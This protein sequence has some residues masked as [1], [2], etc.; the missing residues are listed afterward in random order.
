MWRLL[1]C[2]QDSAEEH[3]EQVDAFVAYFGPDLAAEEAVAWCRTGD[4]HLQGAGLDVLG[5]LA[6]EHMYP[7]QP[8][9]TAVE[10][11]ADS[12]S[13]NVRWSAAYA[14][15]WLEDRRVEAPLLRLAS[16]EDSDVRHIAVSNLPLHGVE[17]PVDHPVVRALLRALE[18][19]D[20]RVRDWAAFGL[21]TRLDLDTAEVRDALAE[22]LNEDDE[23]SDTAAEAA[24]GLA[25]RSD[26]RAL[27]VLQRQLSDP[28]VELRYVEAA[29]E[30]ADERLLPALY[31]LR[32]HGWGTR[33]QDAAGLA[34]AID[35]CTTTAT[36]FGGRA[37]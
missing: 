26:S 9:L 29:G 10:R 15:R 31:A 35:R 18:G 2:N 6:Q 24:M 36:A 27:P 30:M 3:W 4:E 12:R 21:G 34:E 8:L 19:P 7:L 28:D 37:E 11:L 32:R 22:H 16:D 5:V 25:R 23:E 20:P 1:S 14:L 33:L 17:Y 13:G